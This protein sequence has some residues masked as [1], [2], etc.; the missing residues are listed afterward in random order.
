M[1]VKT[2]LAIHSS[3][4]KEQT[5]IQLQRNNISHKDP[6]E[7]QSIEQLS[8][9]N[10]L[11]HTHVSLYKVLDCQELCYLNHIIRNEPSTS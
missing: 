3:G 9:S 7:L 2:F 10:H 5:Q 1:K 11:F 8:S 4:R 6:Q